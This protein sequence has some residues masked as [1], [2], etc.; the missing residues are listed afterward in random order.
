MAG[1]AQ[2]KTLIQTIGCVRIDTSSYDTF[3]EQIPAPVDD[4]VVLGIF[5]RIN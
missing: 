5:S 3:E 2:E 4:T 1:G